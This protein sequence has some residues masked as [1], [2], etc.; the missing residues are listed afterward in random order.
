M[1]RTLFA[2]IVA[3]LA[4]VLG[5]S[6]LGVA[7]AAPD[8]ADDDAM[9]FAV[10]NFAYPDAAKALKEHGVALRRG[11]GHIVLADCNVSRDIVVLS[12]RTEEPNPDRGK[13]CFKVTGTGKTG[14]L[15]L[16]IPKVHHL[17]T[18]DFAIRASLTADGKT[19]DVSVDK[20]EDASVGQGTKAPGSPTV[21]VE[22][23]VTG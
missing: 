2:G 23:R 9:S 22:L 11:D 8:P 3:S 15:S 10:E 6:A 19:T 12:S 20:N 7:T 21:L 5:L 16:E 14:Y 17:S 4:A 18:G 1:R 13:F